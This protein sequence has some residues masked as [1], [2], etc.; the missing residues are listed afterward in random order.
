M[1]LCKHLYMKT[2]DLLEK[3]GIRVS[4]IRSSKG[5][6]QVELAEKAHL[7]QDTIYRIENARTNTTLASI[8][9]IANAL[10]V[11]V[12]EFFIQVET[13]NKRSSKKIDKIVEMLNHKDEKTLNFVSKLIK[14]VFQNKL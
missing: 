2:Q 13:V 12:S 4:Q 7:T 5:L 3:F 8:N 11:D 10:N 14:L 1:L 9:D 6:S